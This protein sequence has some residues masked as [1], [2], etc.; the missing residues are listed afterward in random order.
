MEFFRLPRKLAVQKKRERMTKRAT[1]VQVT[2]VVPTASV[3]VRCISV[4]SENHLYLAGKE[5]IPTHNTFP[6]GHLTIVGANSAAG[7]ASRPIRIVL[8][9]E[10]DRYPLSAGNEG[11]PLGLALKRTTT[12]VGSRKHIIVSTPTEKGL[13]RIEAAYN[14][15]TR[16]RWCYSCPSCGKFQPLTWAQIRFED[17]THECQFC[18][19]RAD[20]LDWKSRPAMWLAEDPDATKA[21]S[22]HINELSSPWKRWDEIISEFRLAKAGGRDRLRVWVNTA[23]GETFEEQ[24]DTLDADTLLRR[25]EAYNCELPDGVLVLTAAVDVQDNRLEAEVAGWGLG[26]ESWGIQYKT[27]FGDPAVLE[28][29]D[30]TAP[31]VWEQLDKFLETVFFYEDG[32]GLRISCTCIDSG[33]HHTT[34]VYQFCVKREHR[35]IFAIRGQGTEGV[36]LITKPSRSNR[37][38]CALFSVGV[39][40]AKET[41]FSRIKTEFVGPNYCHFPIEPEKGYDE[42]YF[43]GLVAEKRMIRY[44][45]GQPKVEWVKPSGARNEPLDLRNYA[46]AALEILNP[47]LDVLA[48]IP[49]EVVS[50]AQNNSNPQGR[51]RRTLSSGV[52]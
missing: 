40:A 8:A 44:Y 3:P 28:S 1:R 25:R 7:L 10:V 41:L 21:R 14:E 37:W 2:A 50:K 22:F 24:G 48:R 17:V 4:D 43:R 26:K 33:G 52:G 6:G 39:N 34:E 23:L 5:M 11:D 47:N 19:E 38:H 35:R 20:E 27:F 16:E 32:N 30:P 51:R 15:G 29:K 45:K 31:S 9:D 46:T 36:P 49:R 13:S 42:G 18:K 12:F